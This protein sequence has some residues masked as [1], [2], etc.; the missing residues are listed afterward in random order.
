MM[1]RDTNA[2]DASWLDTLTQTVLQK[3][4]VVLRFSEDEWAGL[5]ESRGGTHTFTIAR[6]YS[7]LRNVRVPTACILLGQEFGIGAPEVIHCG[8]LESKSSNTTLESRLKITSAG[9]VSP[10]S[11]AQL[12]RLL[13]DNALKSILRTRLAEKDAV[14]LL[15][16]A[17]SA[18]LV[19]RLARR[20]DNEPTLR[21]IADSLEGPATYSDN[22]SLQEDA[23]SLALKAFGLLGGEAAARVTTPG[24][25]ETVLTRRRIREDAVIEHDARVVPGFA[26]SGSDLTGRAVFRKGAEVLEVI[27]ANKRPLE[28]ALGV[29]LIYLNAIKQNV[30]LVQYKMLEP[31]RSDGVTD[32]LY[33]PDGQLEKELARMQ[34]FSRAHKPSPSE[35]RINPQGFYL[36]FVRRD[37]LLGQSAVIMPVEH[38]EVLRRDPSS[39]GPKGAFRISYDALDGRYLRQEGFLEL[40]RCGYIGPYAKTTSALTALIRAVLK[41]DRAVVAAVQ[42]ALP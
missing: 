6:S 25:R 22:R 35:Y 21:A 18:H 41:D 9:P 33:R 17:L 4:I 15:S 12:L 23:V 13:T 37:A 5:N 38:F 40:V 30:V 29:D 26:L 8:L 42:S 28:E 10:S 11:E 27:T 32:W 36:R 7:S 19:E 24:D 34:L 16:P 31:A 39:Q 1:A 20:P 3:P 2:V 14:T